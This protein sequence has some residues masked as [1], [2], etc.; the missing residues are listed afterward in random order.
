MN[1]KY[2]LTIEKK[3]QNFW[4]NFN[5]YKWNNKKNN[6]FS[7]DTPPP[8]ISGSLHMGH[9]FSYA[10]IDFIVR[11]KRMWGK[12][13]FYPIG[14][15]NNGLPTEQ[16]V[17]KT[18]KI[19]NKIFNKKLFLFYCNKLVNQ[20]KKEFKDLFSSLGISFDWSL[21]YE[22]INKNVY[23]ISQISF[24]DLY[25]K[26]KV[27]R[28]FSPCF[29]DIYNQSSITQAEII[30]KKVKIILYYIYVKNNLNKKFVIATTRPEMLSSCIAFFFHPN[31]KRHKI[32]T[33]K[34]IKIPLFKKFAPIFKDN[35]I[36]LKKG[37]G[38]IMCCTFGNIQD[39]YLWRKHKLT[40]KKYINKYGKINNSTFLNNMKI[41]IG[42][43]FIIQ[44][45]K[46]HNFIKKRK[47]IFKFLKYSE[48]SN[49][50]LEIIPTY[51]WY[52]NILSY[53]NEFTSISKICNWYPIDMKTIILNWIKNINQDWCISR[54]RY[55]GITF[56]IYFSKKTIE[57][58]KIIISSNKK[59]P[60]FNQNYINKDYKM[61]EI[62]KEKSI[63]DTWATSSL[64][65]YINSYIINK[66][67]FNYTKRYNK[68][69]PFSLRSQSH[70][71]IRTWS[72]TTIV[73]SLF[74]NA[75]IPWTNL[76]IS[77]WCKSYD[78]KKMSKSK[79][80]II[81]PFKILKKYSSDI[82]RY[83]AS[84]TTLGT[85][86]I[87]NEH[88]FKIG[89]KLIDKL[90]NVTKFYKL[91]I[92]RKSINLYDIKNII[93]KNHIF[94]DLDLWLLH[95]VSKVLIRITYY[96]KK[97]NYYDAKYFIE[98][99]FF[100][101]FCTNYLELIKKR[102]YN[103]KKYSKKQSTLLTLNYI[104]K[105]ILKVLNPFIPHTTDEVN[106]VLFNNK[107]S[108]SKIR[109]W[110]YIKIFKNNIYMKYGKTAIYILEL[111]RQ[112]KSYNKLSLNTPINI[113]YYYG[114]QITYNV[115]E[116][117]KKASNFIKIKK[118]YILKKNNIIYSKCKNYFI[119]I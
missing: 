113:I 27:L 112:Y 118:K 96:L 80:N 26:G 81:L 32:L 18:Y 31:D 69:F 52:I 43:K 75:D 14:F 16:L 73:K 70:E 17:E 68:I 94:Y 10:Q 103:T 100:D 38:L 33:N 24:I 41:K 92:I 95:N 2:I 22:T 51:Q 40:I 9:V 110:P 62:Y 111:I 72:F 8:T 44:K 48:K 23:K 36:I 58:G 11:F 56:P 1:R 12:N 20:T 76:I 78:K 25:Y 45:L 29:W 105:F 30:K 117:I 89:K 82:I 98:K 15:D 35:T 46:Y 91:C 87:F 84:N 21:Q 7:I 97:Y 66:E 99:F 85:D 53:K 115:L 63:M 119:L 39:I 37:T 109:Q 5:F 42:K 59:L 108:L 3:W 114:P 106:Q 67:S 101:I 74:H 86:I 54:Q 47:K 61:K 57:L 55:F 83:W 88:S 116:D 77:G 4:Q 60:T 79:G 28:K 65:P 34:Y 90:W 6:K 49:I 19:K 104:L 107:Y 71:I 102:I 13:I 93:I 64:T 50:S